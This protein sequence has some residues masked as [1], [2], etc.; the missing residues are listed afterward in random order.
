MSFSVNS[1]WMV[2]AFWRSRSC[3][4]KPPI[5]DPSIRGS[6]SS[7]RP[8]FYD[9]QMIFKAEKMLTVFIPDLP[10]GWEG[11]QRRIAADLTV[12]VQGKRYPV[13]GTPGHL[14]ALRGAVLVPQQRRVGADLA[15][16]F[17]GRRYRVPF[18]QVG[19][20]VFV[21]PAE[22]PPA[23]FV[24]PDG[25]TPGTSASAPRA[26]SPLR[27]RREPSRSAPPDTGAIARRRRASTHPGI[28][29]AHP[30][31]RPA[32]LPARTSGSRAGANRAIRL[33]PLQAV[34]P[35]PAPGT[36]AHRKGSGIAY[37]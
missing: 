37:P 11:Q 14:V 26:H 17:E 6:L 28:R 4:S 5:Y 1:M 7:S 3:S 15:I 8:R 34:P 27:R 10:A 21:Q 20:L 32:P 30:A 33:L 2:A 9:G 36:H 12:Q 35:A 24:F 23:V 31:T 22:A 29:A 18:A 13:G 25:W 19:A 16:T